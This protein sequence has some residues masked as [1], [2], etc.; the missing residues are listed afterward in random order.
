M[1]FFSITMLF[2]PKHEN[3][4]GFFVTFLL[5]TITVGANILDKA[6]LFLSLSY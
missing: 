5:F 3:L 4:T 6:F 1:I 2:S